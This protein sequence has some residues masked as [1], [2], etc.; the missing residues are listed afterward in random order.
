MMKTFGSLPVFAV[1][2]LYMCG[3]HANQSLSPFDKV[4]NPVAVKDVMIQTKDTVIDKK[5]FA[6]CIKN[7]PD[8]SMYFLMTCC[9]DNT[10]KSA[11]AN[12][13]VYGCQNFVKQIV[14][15]HN[16]LIDNRA[17]NGITGQGDKIYSPDGKYYIAKTDVPWQ[18]S[19]HDFTRG[20]F[21]SRTNEIQC[22]FDCTDG[23]ED[24]GC[25]KDG[26]TI[27]A[28]I[29]NKFV[30]GTKVEYDPVFV[31]TTIKYGNN[32]EATISRP[33]EFSEQIAEY[34]TLYHD[35]AYA[36]PGDTDFL[37]CKQFLNN[38]STISPKQYQYVPLT[39]G[40]DYY[41]LIE[42]YNSEL[43]HVLSYYQNDGTVKTQSDYSDTGDWE[44]IDDYS[45]CSELAD[46]L[47]EIKK[48]EATMDRV[49]NAVKTYLAGPVKLY[50]SK[51]QKFSAAAEI[52]EKLNIL[53]SEWYR[54]LDFG[55]SY[56]NET[57]CVQH[58]DVVGNV[59][60]N[61]FPDVEC[62]VKNRI[63]NTEFTVRF[64]L[65]LKTP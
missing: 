3:G 27:F 43:L 8:V 10:K 9:L 21:D 19:F 2:A 24:Y 65:I 37:D 26:D 36:Q 4:V 13:Q 23:P 30:I 54:G 64:E 56:V 34:N 31:M 42:K 41:W 29:K 39:D 51:N 11:D 1:L 45:R 53:D 5:G 44:R 63:T 48:R 22:F 38:A 46:K 33:V 7:E 12:Q 49:E 59:I 14:N 18:P 15:A 6:T 50:I 58:Y 16:E 20:V 60:T 61:F 52:N 47:A 40:N 57:D 35:M 55:Y 25:T 28:C 17:N 32:K 62:K